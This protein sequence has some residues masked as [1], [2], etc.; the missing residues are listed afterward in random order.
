MISTGTCPASY[1]GPSLYRGPLPGNK[2]AGTRSWPLTA[3]YFE[4]KE[5]TE[6]RL[7]FLCKFSCRVWL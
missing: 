5:D 4:A 3:V 2:P 7:D 6:I 1:I